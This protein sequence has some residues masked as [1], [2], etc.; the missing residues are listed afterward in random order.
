MQGYLEVTG[1]LEK[2]GFES[3]HMYEDES[4]SFETRRSFLVALKA[5]ASRADWFSNE[6]EILIRLHQRINKHSLNFVDA[7]TMLK[8]QT[9]SKV[10]ETAYCRGG[11]DATKKECKEFR[12]FDPQLTNIPVS[13]FS[14]A[15]SGMGEHSGRGLF[16]MKDL[17]EGQT[18]GVEKWFLSYFFLPSTHQIIKEMSDWAEEHEN[19]AFGSEVLESFHRLV[20]FE[21][22]YGFWSVELGRAH[23]TVDSGAMM[24]CNH[25]CNGSYNLGIVTGFTEV[26]VDLTKPPK[27]IIHKPSAFNP[28]KERNI[29]QYLVNHGGGKAN[30]NITQGEELLCDYLQYVGDPSYWE[31]EIGSL[32]GQ[33]D[34]SE[35]GDITN[36]EYESRQNK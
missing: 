2:V 25:G 8:Y 30:R 5:F 33:C 28:V 16:A 1:E 18:I 29:R 6:A 3:I 17:L 13:D 7:P 11:D 10:V 12:G 9:P 15:Q 23:A 22:G 26:N 35:V 19:E 4:N 31:E 14:V 32:R 34:G 21:T 24:F 27:E 36:Y 20:A